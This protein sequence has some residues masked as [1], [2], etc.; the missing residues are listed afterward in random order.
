VA[1]R[2]SKHLRAARPLS[3]SAAGLTTK[4]DGAFVVRTVAGTA[5]V[6]GYR[7]PGCSQ[8]IP[9]GRPHVVTW[10]QAFGL[11]GTSGLEERRHW[12][13]SCWQRRP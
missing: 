9:P 4:V 11:T 12:H 2:T 10:P 13:T 7:C 3:T 1:R 5:A 8:T 6:K